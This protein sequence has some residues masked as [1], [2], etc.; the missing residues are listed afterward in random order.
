MAVRD[1]A[2]GDR[3]S[4]RS[5]LLAIFAHP[6]D[7]SL[8]CG[9]LLARAAA[10]GARVSLLCLTRGEH[11]PTGG[12]LAAGVTLADVRARELE[13]A[14]G[15]L[16][17]HDVI[18]RDHEDGMLP[19]IDPARL[20]ADILEAIQ[21]TEADVVVT[22]DE[23]GLYGHPDHVAVHAR[24]TAVVGGLGAV[25]PALRYA[26][27]RPGAMRELVSAASATLRGGDGGGGASRPAIVAGLDPDAFGA[28]APLP[29][30]V[31]DA[32]R[33]AGLKLRA[34]QCHRTQVAGSVFEL[35]TEPEA[36]IIGVEHYR[37][38][39]VGSGAAAF[40]DAYCAP[41]PALASR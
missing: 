7:E 15:V 28:M 12:S 6:D 30:L 40:V 16:G 41:A 17:I 35:L 10:E 25:G 33:F 26:S 24:T 14:A 27:M 38:A 22:F 18:L 3:R 1:R 31:L 39:S 19:W 37:H 9:G 5:S 2:T 11:G 4:L 13:A 29:T 23:D 34:L 8:A 21:S 20:D 32:G 36:R